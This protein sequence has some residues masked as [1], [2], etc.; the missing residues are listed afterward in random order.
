M[1]FAR[2]INKMPEFYTIFVRKNRFCPNLGGNCLP[3]PPS[4]TPMHTF[5]IHR[6]WS[7]GQWNI[8]LWLAS[9]VAACHTWHVSDVTFWQVRISAR[10]W[11]C[12]NV[13]ISNTDTSQS[14]VATRWRCIAG[15][16]VMLLLQTFSWV[17]VSGGI[18]K[19]GQCLAKKWSMLFF[20]A[21]MYVIRPS[22]TVR[23]IIIA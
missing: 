10:Q 22:A 5:D 17:C 13:Q 14:S 21:Y 20:A 2:K 16:L 1:R 11:W 4:P 6:F 19:I 7:Q 12:P 9:A 3:C 15:S 23:E 18:L 8:L